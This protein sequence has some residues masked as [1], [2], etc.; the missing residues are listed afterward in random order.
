VV[1]GEEGA[2]G[3]MRGDSTRIEARRSLYG[4]HREKK[5]STST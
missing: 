3:D 5:A 2:A 1:G 4:G